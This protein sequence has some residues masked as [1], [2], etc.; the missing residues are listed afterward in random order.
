M[1]LKEFIAKTN[2]EIVR[3]PLKYNIACNWK[4]ASYFPMM[5]PKD[6]YVLQTRQNIEICGRASDRSNTS[7][8]TL[9][10][11][12]KKV[13]KVYGEMMV[14]RIE[15][16]EFRQDFLEKE[17]DEVFEILTKEANELSDQRKARGQRMN[18]E[19]QAR[20][21]ELGITE[22]NLNELNSMRRQA[23]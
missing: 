21:K 12:T 22:D 10:M 9:K 13:G 18:D 2:E 19:F 14:D 16:G 1:T 15:I 7:V 11:R 6:I 4:L 17:M 8:L 23:F 5:F 3:H 20:L